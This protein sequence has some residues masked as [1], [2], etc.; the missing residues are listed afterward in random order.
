MSGYPAYHTGFE[1][2]SLVDEIYDPEYKVFRACAQLNLRLGL[3]LAESTVLPFRM[4][5]YAKVMEEGMETLESSGV[6]GKVRSLGVETQYWNSSVFAFRE[7]AR[8]FDTFASQVAMDRPEMVKLVNDQM[9][10]F[11][12]NFL[13]SEGLP[14]RVQYRHVIVAPSLFDAYGG[15]AFPGVGDLVY[16]IEEEDATSPEHSRLLKLLRKHV[17]DLMIVIGRATRHLLP[18]GKL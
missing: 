11:E 3:E 8:N 9:R 6:L 7:V 13:L 2:F 18:L 16:R 10:G 15:S 5:N 17:S 1:T 14:D 12:R 4:E